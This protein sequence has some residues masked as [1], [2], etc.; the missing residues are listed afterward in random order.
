MFN[1]RQKATVLYALRYLAANY[2]DAIAYDEP[3]NVSGLFRDN[4][5]LTEKELIELAEELETSITILDID[6]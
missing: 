5:P 3:E 1:E 2:D 6:L 4:P